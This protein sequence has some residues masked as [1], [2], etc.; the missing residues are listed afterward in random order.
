MNKFFQLK[1]FKAQG[2][3]NCACEKLKN[4]IAS[5]KFEID[6]TA[7]GKILE[8][9]QKSTPELQ[10]NDDVLHPR[11]CKILFNHA[12]SILSAECFNGMCISRQ[13]PNNMIEY[14]ANGKTVYGQLCEIVQLLG[15]IDYI[16]VKVLHANSLWQS[17]Q[18]DKVFKKLNVLH[19]QLRAHTYVYLLDVAMPIAY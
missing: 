15:G 13:K 19:V 9:F 3:L 4:R 12:K 14:M 18:L 7:Y 17:N 2:V 6:S 11:N 8:F 10:A 16:V 1:R 5:I